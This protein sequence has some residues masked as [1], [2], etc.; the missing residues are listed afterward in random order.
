MDPGF[1]PTKCFGEAEAAVCSDGAAYK[2]KLHQQTFSSH[3]LPQVTISRGRK[4]QVSIREYTPQKCLRDTLTL[5]SMTI[6]FRTHLC[7][8]HTHT[9][10]CEVFPNYRDI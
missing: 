9:H 7:H 2:D 1:L 4:V 3:G 10:L 6:L 5:L 8:T